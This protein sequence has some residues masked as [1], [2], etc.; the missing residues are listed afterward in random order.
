MNEQ[1]LDDLQHLT[2]SQDVL[3]HRLVNLGYLTHDQVNE[4]VNRLVGDRLAKAED[5]LAFAHQLNAESALHQPQIVSRCYYAMYH[6]ARAVI[7]QFRRAD[8]DDHDRLPAILGQ[9]IGASYGEMLGRWR[10][11]RNQ[12]DYSPYK[13]TDLAQQATA[14]LDDANNLLTACRLFLQSRGVEQ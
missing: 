12:A 11:A 3:L 10:K 14:V 6:A 13:A 9:V 2:S 7:L 5:Y 1:I 8:L 4:L